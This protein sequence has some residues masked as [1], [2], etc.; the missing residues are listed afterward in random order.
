M[1]I[2]FSVSAKD[3]KDSIAD[4]YN[5]AEAGISIPYRLVLP[6]V[7][8]EKYT[9]PL[10]VFFHGAGERGF[11]NEHQLDHCVQQIADHMPKAIILVPQ[12]SHK[13]QWVDTPWGNGSYST[14]D[15]PE[16][17]ELEAVMS[18]VDQ[19]MQDYSVN[20]ETVYAMGISMGGYAVWDVMI[21]HNDVFAAGVAV[22][23]AGDPSKAEVLKDTPMFVFHGTADDAV[24][25]SGSTD[26]VEAIQ[27]IG[28][29]KVQYTEYEGAGHGIWGLVFDTDTLY[30]D[31]QKCKLSD[32][33]IPEPESWLNTKHLPYWIAG[34]IGL[35][36]TVFM[37]LFGFKQKR[38]KSKQ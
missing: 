10:V 1:G 2:P 37:T 21:R 25:V 20:K 24:P 22:C 27:A 9:F 6:E 17:Y 14:D 38:K 3:V 34:S 12:C 35:L 31:V 18:L 23:G 11:E 4:Y 13:D 7:Y 8:D 32:H 28:G 19:I 30:K 29:T 16:S 26:M 33:Y 36:A 5:H 15:V